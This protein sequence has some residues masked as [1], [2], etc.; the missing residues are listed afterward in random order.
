MPA[1]VKDCPVKRLIKHS[2]HHGDLRNALVES[3]LGLMEERGTADF[4]LR[5]LASRVGVSAAAPYAHFADKDSLLA[6]VATVGFHRLQT[7]LDEATR[8]IADPGEKLLA[9]GAAYVCFGVDNPALYELMFNGKDLPA[10]RD[11]FPEVKEAANQAF[12]ILSGMLAALQQSGFL[13]A[14]D[15]SL[16]AFAIWAHVHGL[17]SL[18]LTGRVDC[19]GD[20]TAGPV[21]PLADLIRLSLQNLL[22]G[23]RQR[24][25]AR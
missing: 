9:M 14:G 12:G 13:R 19:I 15:P 10:K 5:D 23:L 8:D 3:A 4:T 6:A 22:D 16:D 7:A 2:Y 1:K 24:Q 25:P 18:V 11:Q 17:A 20:V 21:P